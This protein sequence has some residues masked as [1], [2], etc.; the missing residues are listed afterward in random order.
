MNNL[1]T[2]HAEIFKHLPGVATSLSGQPN[3]SGMQHSQD[4]HL[5]PQHHPVVSK[6]SS[7]LSSGV[8]QRTN[9]MQK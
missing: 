6:K 9:V 7:T 1:L 8:V 5:F 4:A 2:D 3:Y